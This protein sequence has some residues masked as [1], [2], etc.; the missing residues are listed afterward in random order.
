M[1]F[2]AALLAFALVLPPQSDLYAANTS[3][4]V[5]ELSCSSGPYSLR[6]PDTYDALRRIGALVSE[7]VVREEKLGPYIARYRDL[8]FHGLRLGVVTYSND[9][10]KYQVTSAE[11]RSPQWKIAGPFRA[12]QA[13]PP[14]IGDVATKAL[15]SGATVEFSGEEDT[16]RVKLAG[17][18]ISVL[19]YLCVAE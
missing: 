13:L 12:G 17:R 2:A 10:A 9:A 8:V 7:R 4:Y 3:H 5:D 14:K 18:R 11:I 15:S 1:K 19:T 16:V 6:L